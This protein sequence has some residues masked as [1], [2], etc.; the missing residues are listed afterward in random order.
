VG[1]SRRWVAGRELA[2][3]TL[4][5]TS[6]VALIH[7]TPPTLFEGVDWLQLHLPARHY[8]AEALRAGRLPLW[9]PHVALGRPFLADVETAVFYPP[10]LLYVVLDPST[11]WGLLTATH[12]T[13]AF[14]GMLRLGRHLRLEPWTRWLCAALFVSAEP[15]V[16]RVQSGQ[17]HYAHAITYLP[18]VVWLAARLRER[19]TGARVLGLALALALQLLC[20]HPQIAWL[21]WLG[22]GAFLVG[23]AEAGASGRRQT[24]VSLGG[25]GAAVLAALLLAAPTLLPFLEMIGQGNRTPMTPASA[26]EQGLSAFYWS[27]LAVPDGGTRAFYWEFHLYSSLAALVGG[28]AGLTVSL[29]E[30]ETRGLLAAGALGI[31]LGSGGHTPVFGVL[32]HLVP[33]VSVFRIHARAGLLLVLALILGLGLFLSRSVRPR[34]SVFALGLGAVAAAALVAIYRAAAPD[35]IVP[36]PAASR[37]FWLAGVLGALAAVAAARGTRSRS[38]ASTGLVL[39]VAADLVST[40]PPSKAA[41]RF[42]VRRA[43]ERSIHEMLR[44]WGLFD[45]RGV[46]PRVAIPPEVARENAGSIF[47]WSSIAGYQAV[48]LA[49]VWAFVHDSLGIAPPQESTFPSPLIYSHGPFPYGSMSL[50]A[51]VDPG[52]SRLVARRDPDPRAY[53]ASAS[54][55]VGSWSEAVR[56]M[57]EGHDFHRVALLEGPLA[58]PLPSEPRDLPAR[59]EISSFEAERISALAESPSPAVLVLAEP[60]YPGWEA[61]VDGRPAVCVPANGWM[62]AVPVP[63]GRHE[64]V[65]RF[66]SRWLLTGVGLSAAAFVALAGW[67]L[68]VRGGSR[69]EGEAA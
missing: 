21:S 2:G 8:M 65:L 56:L 37:L 64:V 69:L 48:S 60:W 17:V 57:R 28:V 12:A 9:N 54:R 3:A 1:L 62:R 40:I 25:L 34:A 18:L 59:A 50:V 68:R 66:R 11:A 32:Y 29:R 5:A 47:E 44:Q 20:G 55:V 7:L 45:A 38:L 67:A 26:G 10:N 23:S 46:P 43:G 42:E 4:A 15:L 31:L 63:P 49:R 6:L 35:S 22:L 41:W 52:Q 39:V 13:L 14:W 33:G 53:V 27:S 61:R 36:I 24:L 19:T 58:P 30:R 51:G 16:A